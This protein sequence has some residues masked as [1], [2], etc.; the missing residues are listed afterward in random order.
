MDIKVKHDQEYQQFTVD[1]GT[2]NA[3][4]AYAKPSSDVLNFT[5]T[6]VPAPARGK[7]L[8]NELIEAGLNFARENNFQVIASCPVVA[9]YIREHD[10]Y[11]DLLAK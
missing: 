10:T 5:H 11:Q 8:A 4:L 9:R 2:Q 3:E 7:G 6:F 1:L